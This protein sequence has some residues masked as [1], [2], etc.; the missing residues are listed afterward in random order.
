GRTISWKFLVL[1]TSG[2]RGRSPS[3]L[4]FAPILRRLVGLS[5]PNTT[6]S[7]PKAAGTG[8]WN[9]PAT[10]ASMPAEIQEEALFTTVRRTRSVQWYERETLLTSLPPMI[11]PI[12]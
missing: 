3:E 12:K 6:H 7:F 4:G 8:A 11:L 9:Q 1:R 5:P 2:S 10:C